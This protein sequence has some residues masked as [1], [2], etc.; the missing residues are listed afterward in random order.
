[1]AHGVVHK[2]PKTGSRNLCSVLFLSFFSIVRFAACECF[3]SNIRSGFGL[4][5][6]MSAVQN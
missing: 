2:M 4:H 1:M 3:I 5:H 6:C